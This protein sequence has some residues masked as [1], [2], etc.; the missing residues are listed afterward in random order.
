M[1]LTEAAATNS[2]FGFALV[3]HK[4]KKQLL[5]EENQTPYKACFAACWDAQ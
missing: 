5:W 3:D 1:G 4:H 2:V